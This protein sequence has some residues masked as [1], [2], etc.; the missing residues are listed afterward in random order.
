M[1]LLSH[2]TE[3]GALS[4]DRQT[5]DDPMQLDRPVP[6]TRTTGATHVNAVGTDE[7]LSRR[8]EALVEP[9]ERKQDPSHSRGDL[10]FDVRGGLRLAAR[11]P[12]DGGVRF[13]AQH[14]KPRRLASQVCIRQCVR[15]QL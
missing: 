13:H 5:C 1:A 11:R 7:T 12:L 2:A 8:D 14:F 4:K 15:L 3:I 10:T 6:E 9:D